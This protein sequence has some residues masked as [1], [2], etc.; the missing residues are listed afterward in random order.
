[1]PDGKEIM[2]AH[3]AAI[4][5]LRA[6]ITQLEQQK[7]SLEGELVDMSNR[8]DA[9]EDEK[10][11]LKKERD[12]ADRKVGLMLRAIALLEEEAKLACENAQRAAN[13]CEA[14]VGKMRGLRGDLSR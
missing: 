14:L 7:E 9:L 4:A 8:N 6:K 1:M 2:D 13:A 11:D 12:E 10:A 5:P 3:E